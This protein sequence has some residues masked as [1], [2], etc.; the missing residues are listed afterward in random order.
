MKKNADELNPFLAQ[1]GE[2]VRALRATR[3]LTRK[4]LGL[5]A[6]VSERHLANLEGGM[7]NISVLILL[8]I[9][10]ALEVSLSQLLDGPSDHLQRA[11]RLDR[12]AAQIKREPS[13][14]ELRPSDV[15][16]RRIALI[17]LRGAGKSS[18]G[19]AVS[20]SLGY[21]FI[22]ISRE[23]ESLANASLHEIYDLYGP[24]G[25]RRY[26]RQVLKA[27]CAVQEPMVIA[28]PGGIVSNTDTYELLL[29]QCTTVWLKA[30]PVD[31][32]ARVRAQGDNRPMLS[33]L[34]THRPAIDDLTTILQ[35]R[36]T[37]YARADIEFDTSGQD[38]TTCER[39]LLKLLQRF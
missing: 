16:V 17:G 11:E 37:E 29:R 1:L 19:L 14:R 6:E 3:N 20:Q 22:E 34:T 33:T 31:H 38:L 7:G 27:L 2:R 36:E 15:P 26:E 39:K 5:L 12:D 4:Q 8:E 25:Y 28:V 13:S 18:L 9:A 35:R 30:A 10:K 32:I 23:I 24:A 21:H